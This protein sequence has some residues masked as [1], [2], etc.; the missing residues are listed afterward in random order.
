VEFFESE[1]KCSVERAANPAIMLDVQFA[2]DSS[3]ALRKKVRHAR[4][5]VNDLCQAPAKCAESH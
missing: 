1:K 3:S 4:M 2:L 5:M